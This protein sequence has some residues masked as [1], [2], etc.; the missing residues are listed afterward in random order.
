MTTTKI[1]SIL[2]GKG[3]VIENV[4]VDIFLS[5][6]QTGNLGRIHFFGIRF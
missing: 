4:K 2:T 1:Q 5:T 6:K 3:S